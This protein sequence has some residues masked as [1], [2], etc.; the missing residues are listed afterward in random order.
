M[1]L[2]YEGEHTAKIYRDYLQE[3]QKEGSLI[4]VAQA[5]QSP[6]LNPI[7]LLW[8]ELDRKVKQTTPAFAIVPRTPPQEEQNMDEESG[9]QVRESIAKAKAEEAVEKG[10]PERC[11][12]KGGSGQENPVAHRA[13][14]ASRARGGET[15][16]RRPATGGKSAPGKKGCRIG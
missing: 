5:P 2:L 15:V 12:K 9:K 13:R 14:E 11:E 8:I 4:V 16:A 1:V 10:R 3:D 7:E 6:D